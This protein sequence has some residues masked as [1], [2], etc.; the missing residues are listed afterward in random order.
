ME[1]V[2]LTDIQKN[3]IHVALEIISAEVLLSYS[4][5]DSMDKIF[6]KL[7]ERVKLV[8][9]YINKPY[10]AV[11]AEISKTEEHPA[12]EEKDIP[13]EVLHDQETGEYTSPPTG[14]TYVIP[15]NPYE[16]Q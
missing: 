12:P 5:G 6:D 7:K 3:N 10:M 11:Y 15:N 16:G 14:T 9:S 4:A 13:P 8:E 1:K 2:V